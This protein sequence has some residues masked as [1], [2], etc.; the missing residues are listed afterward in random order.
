[1][2]GTEKLIA[3]AAIQAALAAKAPVRLMLMDELGR[4]G[5]ANLRLLLASV[6]RGIEAGVID[7][8]IGIDVNRRAPYDDH[9][10]GDSAFQVVEI[11]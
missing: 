5:D 1:M 6:Q 9:A 4:L 3:Y 2:S 11:V 7:G 10:T 8:F